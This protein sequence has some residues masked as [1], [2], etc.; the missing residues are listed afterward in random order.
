MCTLAPRSLFPIRPFR[1]GF[2]GE[3]RGFFR[4]CRGKSATPGEG[5]FVY[6]KAIQTNERGPAWGAHGFAYRELICTL[7]PRS[8][9]PIRPFR[10]CL[11][12]GVGGLFADDLHE[13]TLAAAAVELAVEYALPGPEMKLAGSDGDDDFATKDL[14]LDVGVGIV[15]AHIVTVG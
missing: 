14:A 6:R 15:L 9:F 8:L 13:D 7:A 4:D 2:H 12:A 5:Q 3:A 10:E 11:H 1:E